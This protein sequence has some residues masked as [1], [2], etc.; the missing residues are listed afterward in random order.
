M[1]EGERR[2]LRV[3]ALCGVAG[4]EDLELNLLCLMSFSSFSIQVICD[5][6]SGKKA[7]IL[8]VWLLW[9]KLSTIPYLKSSAWSIALKIFVIRSGSFYLNDMLDVSISSQLTLLMFWKIHRVLKESQD[10]SCLY[11]SY[12]RWKSRVKYRSLH[13][14]PRRGGSF[15]SRYWLK[16]WPMVISLKLF[17][18]N[19][20]LFST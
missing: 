8:Y 17:Y 7:S 4:R 9:W 11:T 6:L 1:L 19:S 16:F 13:W 15:T 14:P 12:L 2:R 10:G 20:N 18:I 5:F 3:W